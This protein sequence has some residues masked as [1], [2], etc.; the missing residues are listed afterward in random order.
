MT[1]AT[2]AAAATVL[3]NGSGI[4][5]FPEVPPG[6]YVVGARKGDLTLYGRNGSMHIDTATT[7]TVVAGQMADEGI[8][9]PRGGRLTGTT[10]WDPATSSGGRQL[11][12][13]APDEFGRLTQVARDYQ[14]A[15]GR[16]F[17]FDNLPPGDLVLR[18]TGSR[19][20][21]PPAY[22][23]GASGWWDTERVTVVEG[24]TTS[25]ITVT[26]R[27]GSAPQS[28]RLGGADRFAT[29]V[30]VSRLGY[31]DDALDPAD[32]PIVTI[33]NGLNFPDALSAGPLAA[34]AG[35]LLLVMVDAIPDVVRAELARLN[36]SAIIII[37]GAG[38]VSPSVESSLSQFAPV[39]RIAG[40]DRYAVSRATARFA[41]SEGSTMAVVASG[42]DFPDAL[43]AGPLAA[44][45][46]APMILV[47]PAAGLDAPT[48][49]LLVDL[50]VRTV[51]IAGG[52]GAV[53]AAFA[54]G[55]AT[56]PGIQ[57]VR[58]TGGAN[59]YET[60]AFMPGHTPFTE[61]VFI[62][63]GSSFPDALSGAWLAGAYGARLLLVDQNCVP[64]FAYVLQGASTVYVLGG[65]GVV[66]D[67][68]AAGYPQC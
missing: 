42:G 8:P 68:A 27:D 35:P 56:T 22:W 10:V 48:R 24:Q 3:T 12:V 31:P 52:T 34:A 20:D 41:F 13:Y 47:D 36:P 61:E 38:V 9:F 16:A 62:A 44:S 2:S 15:D 37:G 45:L 1:A 55:L 53:P 5:Y 29:A 4:A 57:V 18:V 43:S 49:Q 39:H 40:A 23:D 54:H 50:G 63:R 67:L 26:V 58:R 28:V 7:I 14:I 25:G 11:S 64:G 60:A 65:P 46:G 51:H 66:S 21:G 30:E 19:G 6:R 33:A 32:G 17:S 59:R